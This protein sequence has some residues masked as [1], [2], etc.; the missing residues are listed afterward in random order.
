VWL[1][2]LVGLVDWLEGLRPE[3][4]SAREEGPI[5]RGAHAT[6][7]SM[8]SL[9]SCASW[10]VATASPFF[11]LAPPVSRDLLL[12]VCSALVLLCPDALSA[13]II[14]SCFS[15]ARCCALRFWASISAHDCM[16][17]CMDAE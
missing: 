11:F 2:G 16:R 4:R 15:H 1:V 14:F 6:H 8:S 10:P 5:D 17:L 13:L 3:S 9:L 7:R 12:A